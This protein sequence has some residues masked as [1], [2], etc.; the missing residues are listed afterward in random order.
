MGGGPT[1]NLHLTSKEKSWLE[2][3]S[4]Q[5]WW[6]VF[7]C[8]QKPVHTRRTDKARVWLYFCRLKN[9]FYLFVY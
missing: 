7:P 8:P 1:A 4:D 5:A 3:R 2:Q 9:P 6:P